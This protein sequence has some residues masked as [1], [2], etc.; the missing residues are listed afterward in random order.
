MSDPKF[1]VGEEVFVISAVLNP[2]AMMEVIITAA[3]ESDIQTIHKN[4]GH[5]CPPGWRYDY[6]KNGE[7]CAAHESRLRK[8]HKPGDSFESIMN[9]IRQPIGGRV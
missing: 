6:M 4:S 7:R 8:K 9:A 5:I 2:G 3:R 1:K